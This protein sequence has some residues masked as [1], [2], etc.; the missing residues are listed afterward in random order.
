M[1][2]QQEAEKNGS[3][4]VDST[5]GGEPASAAAGL[6]TAA[7]GL[8]TAAAAPAAAAEP[9]AATGEPRVGETGERDGGAGEETE[10]RRLP[11]F[12]VSLLGEAPWVVMG[13][14]VGVETGE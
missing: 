12:L 13:G 3:G 1:P 11:P 6:A 7:A 4:A 2:G 5:D 10:E 9:A 14:R 8:V